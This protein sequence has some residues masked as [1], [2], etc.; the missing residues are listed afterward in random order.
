M[1]NL[2]TIKAYKTGTVPPKGLPMIQCYIHK[3]VSNK[4]FLVSD[5]TGT[6]TLVAEK[7]N[8]LQVLKAKVTFYNCSYIDVTYYFD[9]ILEL[10]QNCGS[11]I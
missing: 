10:L 11:P 2:T 9:Y 3:H 5:S 7:D 4:K 6:A 8:H 1:P